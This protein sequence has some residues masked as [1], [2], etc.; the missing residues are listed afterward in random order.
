VNSIHL[1]VGTCTC[2]C[3][4]CHLPSGGFLFADVFETSE[5]VVTH[6]ARSTSATPSDARD[7]HMELRRDAV[8]N[9]PSSTDLRRHPKLRPD[10]A[11]GLDPSRP[12][13]KSF[14]FKAEAPQ[15]PALSEPK[16][17]VTTLSITL[18]RLS[19]SRLL[20]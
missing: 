13:E 10:P 3:V 11:P 1:S 2:V 8:L 6:R 7:F 19:F 17:C 4:R 5:N 14:F 18:Q 15:R 12:Y 16:P 9:L 20:I